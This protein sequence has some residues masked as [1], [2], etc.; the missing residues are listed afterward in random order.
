MPRIARL[1]VVLLFL[2]P[3]LGARAIAA[4]VDLDALDAQVEKLYHQGRYGEALPLA[5]RVVAMAEKLRGPEQ[6]HLITAATNLGLVYHDVGNYAAAEPL[7]K[8]ALATG[9]KLL[10]AADPNIGTL[11]N[12]LAELYRNEGR[13]AEAEPLYRRALAVWEKALGTDAPDVGTALNNLAL[14]YTAQGRYTAAEPLYK[15]AL[16]LEEKTL[17][18]DHPDVAA[19]L[20]NLGELYRNQGRYADAEPLYRR[21]LAIR[22]KVLGPR[23]PTVATV[24]NNLGLLE[25]GETR[26]SDAETFYRQA[27]E[28]WESALGPDHP[29]VA[30]VLD[31]LAETYRDQGRFTEAEPMLQRAIAIREKTLGADHPE[32]ADSLNNLAMLYHMEDRPADA[33]PLYL[34]A[35]AIRQKALGGSH[36]DVAASFNNLAEL[37]R[38]EGRLREAVPLYKK[39]LEIWEKA[40]GA[41]HP[42]VAT[43]LNNTALLA[44][45]E[46]RPAEAEQSFKR[47]LAIRRKLFD[48]DHAQIG[49]LL[50]NLAWLAFSRSDWAQAAAYWRQSTTISIRRAKHGGDNLSQPVAGKAKSDTQ[51]D[52]YRFVGLVKASYRVNKASDQIAREMFQ[53]A[54]WAQSSQAAQSLA[55]MA[56]RG[57]KGDQRLAA[58]VR[59]RQDLVAEW[60]R[61]DA[62]RNAAAAQAPEDR[63]TLA[64]ADNSA[65]LSAIDDRLDAVDKELAADFPDYAA[66]ANPAPLSVEEVQQQLGADEALVLFLDT[67]ERAP[68]PD[69]TFIWVVTRNDARWVRSELGTAG[70]AREVASLRCG[71][72]RD[73]AWIGTRCNDLLKTTHAPGN[74]IDEPLPFDLARAHAL[75]KALFGQVEDLIKDKQLL[76]VPSGALT[77]LPF[78]VLVTAKPP[79]ARPNDFRGYRDAA[80]LARDHAITVLPA[81]ASLNALRQFAKQSRATDAYL[82]FGNPLLDG[83][84]TT[85]PDDAVRA[86][87]A[88]EKQCTPVRVASIAGVPGARAI[89]VNLTD[90]RRLLPLPETADEVCEVANDLGADPATHVYIGVRATETMV[91]QLSEAGTLATARIV[92][93][94]THGLVA[95]DLSSTSEPGLLLTPPGTPSDIDDGFLSA[96]EVAALK[97]DADWVILSACNTAAANSKDTDAL[98]GLA[99]AFFYAGARSL[100][101]SHWSVDSEA[102][103]KLITKAIA[104]LKA[105]PK[106]GRAEAL[107]RSMVS[108]MDTGEDYQSH[109]AA[110]APFV[111]VGEGAPPR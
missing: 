84:P 73:G 54:Q 62:D 101:V 49:E 75:Y 87:L 32:L 34:R 45:A 38:D 13:F 24:L 105:D 67:P 12:N 66:L 35:L 95:G 69:E 97:L 37:Y 80:W 78:Q 65:R 83:D 82:G 61:R 50:N 10:G 5:Q 77:Q 26:Y 98:S 85:Y 100:L 96:S 63:N 23:H 17:P 99:R 21:A 68:T 90:I 2:A 9:E 8:R 58:L 71:L 42:Y 104:E 106:I 72:D 94:A 40:L 15:R 108:L 4:T 36:P 47:A 59:E 33:E 89:T 91:K 74:G 3:G 7:L 27:L 16:A 6:V 28:I 57:A 48:P 52:G 22:Q 102:T 30:T 60:Q 86:R 1:L 64:E 29:N 53:A 88:R 39:A 44:Q 14:L 110:W 81:V 109:P 31:N 92:H 93:F 51:R 46:G 25:W 76:I 18:A 20:D 111:L 79:S 19:T 56:A 103:V 41:N 55:Q 43:A 11:V 70:L 107:R